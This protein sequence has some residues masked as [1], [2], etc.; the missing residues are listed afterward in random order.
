MWFPGQKNSIRYSAGISTVTGADSALFPTDAVTVI[1]T[2]LVLTADVRAT[3]ASTEPVPEAGRTESPSF[4]AGTASA[5]AASGAG[6]GGCVPTTF[7]VPDQKRAV[8]RRWGI[9]VSGR[10]G[11]AEKGA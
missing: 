9:A 8:S 11:A 4:P 5:M 10:V 7:R 2:G 3:T 1:T 6:A